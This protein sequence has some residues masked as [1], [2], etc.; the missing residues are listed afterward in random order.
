MCIVSDIMTTII[1]NVVENCITIPSVF[2]FGDTHVAC[3]NYSNSIKKIIYTSHSTNVKSIEWVKDGKLHRDVPQ[4]T[5]LASVAYTSY[6]PSGQLNI[7]SWWKN[8]KKSC[9]SMNVHRVKYYDNSYR[10]EL[11]EW[12]IHDDY[13]MTVYYQDLKQ[14]IDCIEWKLNDKYHRISENGEHLPARLTYYD[15]EILF[16]Q[17]WYIH[18]NMFNYPT[19]LDIVELKDTWYEMENFKVVCYKYYKNGTLFSKIAQNGICRL[20]EYYNHSPNTIKH[21]TQTYHCNNDKYVMI[22]EYHNTGHLHTKKWLMNDLLH[23][24]NDKPALISYYSSGQIQRKEWWT[25]GTLYR[26]NNEPHVII[27]Y[28]NGNIKKEEWYIGTKKSRINYPAEINY[29][30]DG[31]IMNQIWYNNGICHRNYK[32]KPAY[33]AY[34]ILGTI[35]EQRWIRNGI[36]YRPNKGFVLF[37]YDDIRDILTVSFN[38]NNTLTKISNIHD[39]IQYLCTIFVPHKIGNPTNQLSKFLY[40]NLG[41]LYFRNYLLINSVVYTYKMSLVHTSL[42]EELMCSPP[43]NSSFKGGVV[44]Q[45][46]TNDIFESNQF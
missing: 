10:V 14:T 40:K 38:I 30:V 26:H 42:F 31:N 45:Q 7:L 36:L 32:D 8:G 44:Y 23:N 2:Q 16:S 29:F 34:S 20:V 41:S 1:D 46:I 9:N 39:I 24:D 33:I 43:I 4:P 11:I 35:V 22:S 6:Y 15:D 5:L 37:E 28:V 17:E 18:G 19:T 27:Y 25:C 13:T 12:I 21:S 3:Y